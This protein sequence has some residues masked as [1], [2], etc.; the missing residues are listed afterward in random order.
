MQRTY[1]F[2]DNMSASVKRLNCAWHLAFK[3]DSAA[4]PCSC[5]PPN[6][7]INDL[8]TPCTD[9]VRIAEVRAGTEQLCEKQHVGR[10][11]LRWTWSICIFNEVRIASQQGLLA[12]V[13]TNNSDICLCQ[14]FLPFRQSLTQLFTQGDNFVYKRHGSMLT[15]RIQLHGERDSKCNHVNRKKRGAWLSPQGGQERS[16]TRKMQCNPQDSHRCQILIIVIK[17][18]CGR[19]KEFPYQSLLHG[20]PA[21]TPTEFI[22]TVARRSCVLPFN[23][24]T[25][26]EFCFL[27][28]WAFAI[29]W[30]VWHAQAEVCVCVCVCV[31]V[32][33]CVCVC[34]CVC[35]LEALR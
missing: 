35:V 27:A 4:T 28:I 29:L 32:F 15:D 10:S 3:I 2:Y 33:A 11:H 16:Y 26:E 25:P 14:N 22:Q 18:T 1:C 8:M 7:S 23:I 19:S 6:P 34:V 20:P 13:A 5:S 12:N 21:Y 9:W 24:L 30:L 31:C 17:K